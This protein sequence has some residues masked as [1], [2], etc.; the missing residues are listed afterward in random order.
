[1]VVA[2]FPAEANFQGAPELALAQPVLRPPEGSDWLH[3]IKYDGYRIAARQHNGQEVTLYSRSGR[4]W[5]ARFRLLQEAVAALAVDSAVLDGELVA[6]DRR[7]HPDFSLLQATLAG[8]SSGRLTYQVFDLL[9]LG[10]QDLR[11]EPLE[12]RRQQLAELLGPGDS[13]LVRLTGQ[14]EQP[15]GTVFEHACRLGIEGIISKRR[16]SPVRPGRTGDWL[17]SVCLLSGD[18]VITGFSAGRGE[19][20]GSFGALLL[21]ELNPGEESP[22][23]VGRVGTGFSGAELE[24]LARQLEE[25]K[26]PDPPH[27]GS[28]TAAEKSGVSWV[29]PRLVVEVAYSGRTGG[30]RLRQARFRRLRDDKPAQQASRAA[31]VPVREAAMSR[32]VPKNGEASVSGVRLTNPDRVLY[33]EQGITKLRLAE[34]YEA[35][36]EEQLRWLRDRPLSLVRCPE[37][38]DGSCFYQK[39]PGS[40]FAGHVPRIMI[41]EE[42]GEGEYLLV[43]DTA[44]VIALVQ[45]GVLEIHAWSS[46]VADLERPDIL[47]FDLDPSKD[48]PLSR[49]KTH[50][51]QLRELLN[52]VGLQAFLRVTGGK[53]LHLVVPIEPDTEFDEAK[54]FSRSVAEALAREHPQQLTVNMSKAKRQGRVFIDFLRN[55]RGSTAIT[56]WSTR[57][58]PGAPVALPLRWADLGRLSSPAGWTP[59]GALRRLR[60]LKEDPWAGFGDARR[61]L[62]ELT[63]P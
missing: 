40:S 11:A 17:K 5:T 61:S 59:D 12:E 16:G 46:Q 14:L 62:K 50:A 56:N 42:S 37:G 23:Y 45:A 10:N 33:R 7:G 48:V 4:D 1:M 35:V 63:P 34:Y 49:L 25:L 36:G 28:L 19:R 31:N 43:R 27:H 52:K 57:A 22:R 55:G 58:R 30:G 20:S 9:K 53:G 21:G 51:R 47:V 3:E 13:Q 8:E 24:G 44:D 60:A 6:L 15:G 29:E 26:R 39:H 54:A 18:F 2:A 32:S 41:E 38:R